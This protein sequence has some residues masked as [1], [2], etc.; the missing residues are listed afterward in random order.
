MIHFVTVAGGKFAVDDY[1]ASAGIEDRATV[2]TFRELLDRDTLPF[3]AYVYAGINHLGPAMAAFLAGIADHVEELTGLAPLNHPTKSLRRYELIR[4][5]HERDMIPYTA[6]GAWEDFSDVRFPAFLRPR[7]MDSVPLEL[8]H[9]MSEIEKDLGL[10][11]VRGRRPEELVV[12]EFADTTVSGHYTKYSSYRVG[13]QIAAL[14]FDRGRSWALR[15]NPSEIDLD[16]VR[17]QE[18]FVV[19]NLHEAAVREIFDIADIT[20]GRIDYSMLDG[21][22]VCWEINTLPTLGLPPDVEPIPPEFEEAIAATEQIF[23]ERFASGFAAVLDEVEKA[24][25]RLDGSSLANAIPLPELADLRAAA[26]AEVRDRGV[27]AEGSP[28]KFSF[29][30][31]LLRPLKPVLKPVA[32]AILLSILTRRAR[33]P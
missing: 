33:K 26:R 6:Y 28:P 3:G 30:R 23:A 13:E 22:V 5:L 21:E 8:R 15:Y 12:I 9:S 31:R 11:L 16:V 25:A 18:E 2:L 10:Q 1:V 7:E 20:F 27:R 17:K 14:S 32:S 24:R 29:L 4:A 19:N